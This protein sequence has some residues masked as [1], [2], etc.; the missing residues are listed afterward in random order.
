[1]GKCRFIYWVLL[2]LLPSL[3]QAE[4]RTSGKEIEVSANHRFLQWDDGSPFFYFGDTAWELFHKL[5]REEADMYLTDRAQKG[6]T[7]IQAV[8][9]AE[10]EGIT[11]PNAYGHLPLQ[12]NDPSRPLVR[13][14]DNNDYWDHVDYIVNKANSL[15]LVIA[16]LP[17]WGSYWHD[18]G[19][20]IFQETSAEKY[21]EFLGN[22]YKNNQI[23][24]VLGGDRMPE[25]EAQKSIIRALVKGLK[26]GD[27]GRHLCTYHP[28]GWNGSS[29]AFHQEEWLDFNMRQNGHEVEYRSYSKTLD[30][31]RLQPV[32]PVMD[33]EPVYEDHPVAFNAKDKGHSIAADC[34][35][36]MYWDLFNGAFGH[37]YGHHSIWQMYNP[38]KD[39]GINTPL[40]PWKQAISQPGSS[41]IKH[42]RELLA[43]R[44][45]FSRI[46]DSENILVETDIKTAMP[47]EGRYR[48]VATRDQEGTY[49]MV[50][51]PVGRPFAVNMK[52]LP[53][54]KIK[55][56]WFNPR[57]GKSRMIGVLKNEGT[58]V[59]ET[60]SPG[61][62]ID[63]ILVLDD[64]QFK[65]PIPES[66]L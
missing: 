42:A 58:K 64:A 15:G 39:K 6:F 25:N 45:Y 2:A 44:P 12:D 11:V 38:S 53:A 37:T 60:P 47:G 65:Y 27:A 33:A 17:T 59:F 7:V 9:L 51:A 5:T 8:G 63:W 23:I 56:W 24:W 46:P 54:Q 20:V 57:T 40:Y 19:K 16:F 41:Q 43:S 34:R 61:E 13:K 29:T 1:M 49:L 18:N 50:Y 22:R 21:G 32:K 66:E 48:F 31:Y 14:G 4:N 3:S 10:L 62:M 26:K 35:R 28:S 36:A 30:D 55:A 52:I